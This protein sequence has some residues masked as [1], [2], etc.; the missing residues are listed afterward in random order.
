[1]FPTNKTSCV[2]NIDDHR[3][4]FS[5][6]VH[7]SVNA[8]KHDEQFSFRQHRDLGRKTVVVPKAQLLHCH[9]VIF[10]NDWHDIFAFEQTPQCVSSILMAGATVKGAMCEQKLSNI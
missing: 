10:V 3:N 7:E 6:V 8:C 1:F 5:G 4:P 2:C 9:G